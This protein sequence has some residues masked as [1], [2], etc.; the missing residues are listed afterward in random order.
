[1]ASGHQQA[2]LSASEVIAASPS[3][4]AAGLDLPDPGGDALLVVER[5][6]LGRVAACLSGDFTHVVTGIDRG[7]ELWRA[8]FWREGGHELEEL[9]ELPAGLELPDALELLADAPYGVREALIDAALDGP[10]ALIEPDEERRAAWVAWLSAVLPDPPTFA[11]FAAHP[12]GVRVTA[13]TPQHADAFPEAI[14]TTVPATTHASRYATIA[15]A[16]AGRDPA[17]LGSE[18]DPVALAVAGG[19]TDLLSPEDLPRALE[20][21]TALVGRGEIATAARAAAGLGAQSGTLIVPEPAPVELAVR[22]ESEAEPVDAE[23]VEEDEVVDWPGVQPGVPLHELEQAA[24]QGEA[25]L[26]ALI[27]AFTSVEPTLEPLRLKPPADS[28]REQ[29]FGEGIPLHD[30]EEP[31][32][33]PDERDDQVLEE[34]EVGMSLED[35]EASLKRERDA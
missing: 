16:V 20:L 34:E 15:T 17:A 14:D 4:D 28:T 12:L 21:I 27:R 18:A 33:Q 19:A 3:L 35:F 31:K 25:S 13:T 5:N 24:P 2:Y 1:V 22:S 26:D 11:T 6:G 7:V 9:D 30:L 29:T 32:H 23:V 10:V 8:P